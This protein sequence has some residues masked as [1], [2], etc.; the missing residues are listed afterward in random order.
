MN[1]ISNLDLISGPLPVVL[2]V[3]A[4]IAGAV[5]LLRW[6]RRW[7]IS[8]VIAAVLAAILAWA[9]NWYVVNVAALSAY[10]LPLQVIAWIGVGV[11]AF[12]LMVLHLVSS[13]WWRKILAPVAMALVVAAVAM[14]VN[15]YYGAYRT[16]GDVTGAST[17]NIS[18]LS[19][20]T[21]AKQPHSALPTKTSAQIIDSW[22]KPAGLPAAG[23]VKSAQIP[24]SISGFT[25]RTAYV[26]LPPAYQAPSRPLL[27][28]VVLIPGQPGGPADWLKAGQL[29][30]IMDAFAASHQGLAPVVV[31]PDVTGTDSAN[32]MCMDSQIAK[33]DSYLAVDVPAWIKSTLTVDPNPQHWAVGG[34]SFGGTCALQMATMHPKT[35]PSAIDLSGEAE[36]ALS[37]DRAVTI[38]QAFGGNTAAF[39]AVVPLTLLAKNHY[40]DSWMYFA[41]G[42]QDARFTG[43]MDQVS[44]AAKSSGMTITTHGVLG[45][46]HSWEVPVKAMPL[47]LTWLAPRLGL[48]H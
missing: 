34:F 6:N 26:Y 13:R 16:V 31:V 30:Q 10:D 36:P 20:T 23:T 48:A 7:A 15:I 39:D 4:C 29:K 17:A 28:V 40:P 43:Y 27:P 21:A 9:I 37:A 12:L 33:T 46:G 47:A 18:P 5:L 41:A 38:Q 8:V 2:A 24:G 45:A 42:A 32:T 3:L 14:Q 11:F 1:F 19:P 35:Y 25:G 44:T 22:V